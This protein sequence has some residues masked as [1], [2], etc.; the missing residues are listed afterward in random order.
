MSIHYA[1]KL[2]KIR[3][4]TFL[5]R[6]F[7]TYLTKTS[8]AT[9]FLFIPLLTYGHSPDQS[10]QEASSHNVSDYTIFF[11]TSDSAL[12]DLVIVHALGYQNL[13]ALHLD[14][15]V[16]YMKLLKAIGTTLAQGTLAIPFINI[17]SKAEVALKEKIKEHYAIE[18]TY[19]SACADMVSSVSTAL[20]FH[21]HYDSAFHKN[22]HTH[23]HSY[24]PLAKIVVMNGIEGVIFNSAFSLAGAAVDKGL[25]ELSSTAFKIPKLIVYFLPTQ[26][27]LLLD[28][29]VCH[30]LAHK[31]YDRIGLEKHPNFLNLIKAVSLTLAEGTFLMPFLNGIAEVENY[32]FEKLKDFFAIKR[33][34]IIAFIQLATDVS[35]GLAFH[36]HYD[37]AFNHQDT[38][39]LKQTYTTLALIGAKNILEGASFCIGFYLI[40]AGIDQTLDTI[41]SS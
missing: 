35:L 24:K 8:I 2:S 1:V 30:A 29:I 16:S 9:L 17:L 39:T 32:A 4:T 25:T 18:R 34:Y 7:M 15:E 10:L 23:S 3:V 28:F 11:P 22:S 5:G 13:H 20:A 40:G 31:N 38:K 19:I 33:N 26:E 41:V 27:S 36:M 14:K 6:S 12:F 37:N 21:M